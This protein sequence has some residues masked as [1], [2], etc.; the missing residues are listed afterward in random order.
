MGSNRWGVDQLTNYTMCT[1]ARKAA[2]DAAGIPT[3]SRCQ[4]VADSA[5]ISDHAFAR[6]PNVMRNGVVQ[7][8][9]TSVTGGGDR[10]QFYI[11]F[12]KIHEQ[13]ILRNSNGHRR[14]H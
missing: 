1:P 2:V 6:D 8:L 7:N 5:V 9:S 14:V 12:D 10:Y 11:A 4:G 13:G 3:W